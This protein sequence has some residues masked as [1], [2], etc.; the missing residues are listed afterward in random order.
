MVVSPELQRQTRW[1]LEQWRPAEGLASSAGG[2]LRLNS[3]PDGAINSLSG[4]SVPPA[5]TNGSPLLPHPT[6]PSAQSQPGRP[7]RDGAP[8]STAWNTQAPEGRASHTVA[9]REG[10]STAHVLLLCPPNPLS[11]LLSLKSPLGR[12][13][14]WGL[15]VEE[16]CSDPSFGIP[17]HPV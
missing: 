6:T 9:W 16:P 8:R 3:T 4:E 15:G 7:H 12:S 5:S 13:A 2:E 14:C 17:N 11:P 1:V 10:D